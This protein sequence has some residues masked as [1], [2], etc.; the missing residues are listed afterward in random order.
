MALAALV[1]FGTAGVLSPATAQVKAPAKAKL[2][3]SVK[4]AVQADPADGV[5]DQLN[6]KWLQENGAYAGFTQAEPAVVP[7][8]YATR[9]SQM[10]GATAWSRAP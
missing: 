8:S 10:I 6:A 4:A 3:P 2:K 7:A 1:L 5:A 9:R